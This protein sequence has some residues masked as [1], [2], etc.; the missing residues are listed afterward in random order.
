MI[1][2]ETIQRRIFRFAPMIEFGLQKRKKLVCNEAYGKD[3]YSSGTSHNQM[4]F[5]FPFY[6]GHIVDLGINCKIFSGRQLR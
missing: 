1:D 3:P 6:P 4:N 2:N 5:E